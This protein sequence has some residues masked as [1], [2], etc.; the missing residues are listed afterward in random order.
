MV[1][2]C[3]HVASG[4]SL[5]GERVVGANCSNVN[6]NAR[7]KRPWSAQVNGPGGQ[8]KQRGRVTCLAEL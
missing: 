4:R 6:T 1:V 2:D 7:L 8:N 3:C 5:F